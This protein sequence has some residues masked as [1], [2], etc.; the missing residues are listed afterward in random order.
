MTLLQQQLS[1]VLKVLITC[2][3]IMTSTVVYPALPSVQA[4]PL[5]NWQD[6]GVSFA[7]YA[8]NN[9]AYGN[10]TWLT[11]TSNKTYATSTDG[12]NWSQAQGTF[13]CGVLSALYVNTYWVTACSNGRIFTLP[14]SE[15]PSDVTKWREDTTPTSSSATQL[16]SIATNGTSVVIVA[17]SGGEIVTSQ[18]GGTNWTSQIISDIL[19]F[20]SVTYGAGK[21][22]AVGRDSGMSPVIYTS[23]DG[24]SWSK[25][26]TAAP[27]SLLS[28]IT[29]GNGKFVAV[30]NSGYIYLTEDGG[31]SWERALPSQ[32]A[33]TTTFQ[34]IK[35]GNG[36]FYAGGAT[37]KLISS[38]DG[39][40]WDPEMSGGSKIIKSISIDNGK[41]ILGGS[42]GLLFTGA[43]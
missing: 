32:D 13:P 11:F 19:N 10:G 31:I 37:Q 7:P 18:V 3:L 16:R 29:Y 39:R 26:T 12:V 24:Y 40:I 34:V 8:E 4:G 38:P 9:M 28:S 36:Y 41:I 22:M 5:I 33:L 27:A 20:Y 42:S 14:G 25:V 17:T 35:Y 23:A 1:R 6:I 2:I 21:Y 30:G 43:I 15:D